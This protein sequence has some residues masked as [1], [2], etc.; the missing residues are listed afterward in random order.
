[1]LRGK[2]EAAL[3]GEWQGRVP[4]GYV[5]KNKRLALATP[6]EVQ[7]VKGIFAWYLGGD[8]VRAIVRRLNRQGKT[9]RDGTPWIPSTV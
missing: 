2:L 8:S 1:M 6:D 5:L 3:R 9:T 7:T 4:I